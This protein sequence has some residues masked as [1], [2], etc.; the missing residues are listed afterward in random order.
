MYRY[1]T[2]IYWSAE[3]QLYIAE[4]PDLPGCMVHGKTDMEA[5]QNSKEAIEL[6]ISTAKE[7]GDPVPMPSGHSVKFS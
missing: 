5:L 3:D 4:V 2:V 1:E 7:F 6:W